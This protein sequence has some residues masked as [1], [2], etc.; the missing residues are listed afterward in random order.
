MSRPSRHHAFAG[1][2]AELRSDHPLMRAAAASRCTRR[3]SVH[4]AAVL[5]GGTVARAEGA[6]WATPLLISAVIVLVFL[7]LRLALCEQRKREGAIELILEGRDQLSIATVRRQRDRLLAP[8]TSSRLADDLRE[9]LDESTAGAG[10]FSYT[11]PI[12]QRGIIA[13]ASDDLRSVIALLRG[14]HTSPRGIARA[15]RLLTHGTS[16]LYG[17]DAQALRDELANVRRLLASESA[18]RSRLT[19]RARHQR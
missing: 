7:A 6:A 2:A 19:G 14:R 16:P 11:R 9:I 1:K 10:S 18:P 5:A 13:A 12:Y 3:Q 4:V 8:R 17:I 15:E